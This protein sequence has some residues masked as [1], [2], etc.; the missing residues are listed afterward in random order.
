MSMVTHYIGLDVH[1][2]TIAVAVAPR[3]RQAPRSL[4]TVDSS[5]RAV[6][7]KLAA[8]GKPEKMLVCYEAGPTG[9]V[10]QRE[11]GKRGVR[12]LVVAPSTVPQQAGDRVKTD[13]RD[14]LKLAR[15]L[16]SGDLRGIHV[17]DDA[18]EAMRDLSRALADAKKAVRVARQTLGA[19]LLRHGR[20]WTGK[21]SWTTE[22]KEWIRRQKFEH[23]AAERV[24]I[25]YSDTL[26]KAEERVQ[27]LKSS[28]EDL[29]ADWQQAPLVQALQALRGI[30]LIT[31]VAVVAELGDLRRFESAPQLMAFVGLVPREHSSGGT[32]RQGSITKAGNSH[33]RGLLGQSAVSYRFR[34]LAGP[35]IRARRAQVSS[36]V[37][38][39]AEK[40]EKRLCIR[41]NKLRGRGK[42]TPKIHMAIARELLGFIWAIGQLNGPLLTTPQGR[43]A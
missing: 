6:F 35:Q 21:T 19:F 1:A 11:L 39:I 33:V 8:L 36:E 24:L 29:V 15:Y 27:W 17:P 9:F 32:R 5:A 41:F 16:R 28:I 34:P 10:L 3:G 42:E 4:G 43:T 25:D 40:A 37:V 30:G 7:K 31:A 14:A 2:D 26:M 22:H 38:A 23:E 13:R 18:T 12:C 20:R